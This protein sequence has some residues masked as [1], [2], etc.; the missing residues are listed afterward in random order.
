MR[1]VLARELDVDLETIEQGTGPSGR[2][3]EDDVR[4][5]A[6]GATSDSGEGLE[7]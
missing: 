2:V 5:A 3:T 4:A 1:D 6:E 7:S